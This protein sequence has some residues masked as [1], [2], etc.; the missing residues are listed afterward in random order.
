MSNVKDSF[1]QTM[2]SGMSSAWP[3]ETRGASLGSL[4]S[5]QAL[6]Q[7]AVRIADVRRGA[8]FHTRDL[9]S[10][11]ICHAARN[12]RLSQPRAAMR[13]TIPVSAG[14]IAVRVTIPD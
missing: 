4:F 1:G 3:Q 2:S 7:A 5:V 9:V 8:G 11:L 13:M 10:L 14:R 12:R 6:K